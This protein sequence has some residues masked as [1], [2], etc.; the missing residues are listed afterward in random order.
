MTETTL[1]DTE[2]VWEFVLGYEDRYLVSNHGNVFSFASGRTLKTGTDI[3]PAVTLCRDGT[4]KKRLVHS[5]VLEAFVGKRIPEAPHTRHLNGN[6]HDNR[7]C[8][9]KWGT[10]AENQ[11]DTHAHG[12]CPRGADAYDAAFTDEEVTYI[13]LNHEEQGTTKLVKKFG[14]HRDT[15]LR[16]AFGKT[17]KDNKTPCAVKK[18]GR[19]KP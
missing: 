2:E 19:R 4:S 8:N 15:I 3:Y 9:L 17:Y 14:V 10:A 16:A 13:K 5:M 7:L 1:T 12:R 11:A 6:K 18:P